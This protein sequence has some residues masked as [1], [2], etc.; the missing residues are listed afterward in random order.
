MCQMKEK[1]GYV[2]KSQGRYHWNEG[3]QNAKPP[4][5]NVDRAKDVKASVFSVALKPQVD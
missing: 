1:D 2:V 4:V 5:G 3:A